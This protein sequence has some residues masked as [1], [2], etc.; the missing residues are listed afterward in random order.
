MEFQDNKRAL[1]VIYGH[2]DSDSSTNEHHK[3]LHIMYGVS[4]DITS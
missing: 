1:K 2:S 3:T 4:C